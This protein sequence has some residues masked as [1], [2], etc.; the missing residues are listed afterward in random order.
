ML[1]PRLAR[2]TVGIVAVGSRRY[3]DWLEVLHRYVGN[4]YGRLHSLHVIR[5][6]NLRELVLMTPMILTQLRRAICVVTYHMDCLGPPHRYACRRRH[7]QQ[8]RI[9]HCADL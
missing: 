4:S 6:H 5:H 1:L 9:S 2:Y 3:I 8:K 7:Q